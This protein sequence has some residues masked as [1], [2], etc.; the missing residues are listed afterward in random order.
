MSR[1]ALIRV[2]AMGGPQLLESYNEQPP[3]A[4]TSVFPRKASGACPGDGKDWLTCTPVGDGFCQ[5]IRVAARA[6]R[7][8]SLW[9]PGA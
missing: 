7:Q 4:G 9:A 1:L 2:T 8:P 6:D 3:V 5:C